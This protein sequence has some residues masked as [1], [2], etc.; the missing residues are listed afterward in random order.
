MDWSRYSTALELGGRQGGLSLWM[1][2]RGLDVLCSDYKDAAELARPLH[3]A[4]GLLSKVS[5]Q[6]IDATNIPF[7]NHFD[8]VVFKSVLG[9]IGRGNDAAR[10]ALVFEQIYKALKPGGCLLFAENLRASLLHR[11]LRKHFVNWGGDWRYVQR[12]ELKEY[13]GQFSQLALR[14]NGVMAAFGRSEQ[15]RNA[16]ARIDEALF[17]RLSPA[18]WHYIAYGMA[19]K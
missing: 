3:A 1:A 16:F 7:E 12:A 14:S 9:G 15:Q 8:I 4:H 2:H 5:Y 17:N 13:A 6:D 18:G 19:V 10:Q 11:F